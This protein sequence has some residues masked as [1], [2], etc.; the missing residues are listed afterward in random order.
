MISKNAMFICNTN[1]NR[2]ASYLIQD[3]Y[4]F[5]SM[6]NS[7]FKRM[8]M[9][10]HELLNLLN[11]KPSSKSAPSL[12]P[13]GLSILAKTPNGMMDAHHLLG[14]LGQKNIGVDSG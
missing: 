1:N 14:H 12:T 9:N 5:G 4:L 7:M 13:S 11:W 3:I 10:I 8:F 6:S 2:F